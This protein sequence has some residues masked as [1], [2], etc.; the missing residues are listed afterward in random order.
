[1]AVEN[2]ENKKLA[3]IFPVEVLQQDGQKVIR[4]GIVIPR[5]EGVDSTAELNE[6]AKALQEELGS[7][8]TRIIRG[9]DLPT[10]E[11]GKRHSAA[12]GLEPHDLYPSPS[13]DDPIGN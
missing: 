8:N 2:P 4:Y 9:E 7:R 1:M 11:N 3:I 10:D 6:V 12:Q 5:R 13:S